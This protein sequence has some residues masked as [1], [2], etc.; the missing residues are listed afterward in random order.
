MNTS[1]NTPS[2][3]RAISPLL[4]WLYSFRDCQ[5]EFPRE[6]KLTAEVN[7]RNKARNKCP[8]CRRLICNHHYF[9]SNGTCLDCWES[10]NWSANRYKLFLKLFE[11]L[12]KG[13]E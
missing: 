11:K 9:K 6:W 7:C 10:P 13:S 4:S 8:R 1:G 2:N 3:A 5:S 12:L